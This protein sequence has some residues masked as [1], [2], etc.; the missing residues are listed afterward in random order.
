MPVMQLI[1]GITRFTRVMRPTFG[2]FAHVRPR[3]IRS[4]L[5]GSVDRCPRVHA[6]S[7]SSSSSPAIH[8]IVA[9]NRS[10]PPFFYPRTDKQRSYAE[11]L[12]S[13]IA[14]ANTPLDPGSSS[15][16]PS[17]AD[18]VVATGPAGTCKTLC[19]TLVGLEKLTSGEV[20]RLV[21]TRPA[22]SADEELGFL[23]GSLE[24]K[25]RVWLLPV[26]DSL[27]VCLKQDVV[28]KLMSSSTV[29]VCSLSH[30]RGRTFRDSFVVVD[31]CQNTTPAQMLM[32]LTRIGEGSRFVFTGD[33][34]QHDRN[35]DAESGLVDFVHRHRNS[36]VA[37]DERIRLFEF[38]NV[39]IQR[40]R[41]ISTVLDMYHR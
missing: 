41:V 39:D 23:P 16:S 4:V 13:P 21:F 34:A 8:H 5:S 33:P 20:E 18:I 24:D 6:I 30:M 1:P 37:G 19:A 3:S 14:T 26:Y 38:D 28:E 12:R 27:R 7:S 32:L 11:L 40:H 25:M 9:K 29:E 10:P 31:E 17:M 22:V 36:K 35:R 15:S 2:S